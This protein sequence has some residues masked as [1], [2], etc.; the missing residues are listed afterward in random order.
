MAKDHDP[1]YWHDRAA[2]ARARARRTADQQMKAVLLSIVESY[3][4][5]AHRA[6]ELQ[7]LMPIL[8][9]PRQKKGRER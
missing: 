5:L 8:P 3:T 7:K 4:K 2:E 1:K 9:R 6:S